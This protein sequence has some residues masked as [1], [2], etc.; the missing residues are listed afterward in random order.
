MALA[1]R[2]RKKL[3]VIT[4]GIPELGPTERDGNKK[5]GALIA[6]SADHVVILRSMF[7]DEIADGVREAA[8]A[9]DKKCSVFRNLTSFLAV[10]SAQFS[11]DQWVVL[12]QPEL[13]DLYY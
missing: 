13:T 12:V 2:E 4:A 11:P 5:L 3:L 9:G 1:N 8:K 10:A 7:A 6:A